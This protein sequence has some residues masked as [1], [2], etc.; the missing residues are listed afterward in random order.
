MESCDK[1]PGLRPTVL[2][3]DILVCTW[4]RVSVLVFK[5]DVR[6]SR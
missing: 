5:M 6:A 4:A 2:D 1:N 3:A